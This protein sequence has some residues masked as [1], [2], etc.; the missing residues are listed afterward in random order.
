MKRSRGIY[1]SHMRKPTTAFAEYTSL[2]QRLVVTSTSLLFACSS[3]TSLYQ[4]TQIFRN[5]AECESKH[6][7]FTENECEYA[8]RRANK[9]ALR[10]GP[11]FMSLNN[12]EYEFGYAACYLYRAQLD[13]DTASAEAVAAQTIRD[14]GVIPPN[15]WFMPH[16]SGILLGNMLSPDLN[17]CPSGYYKTLWGCQASTAVYH[18]GGGQGDYKA[19]WYGVNGF[20]YGNSQHR[21]MTI[22]K[23]KFSPKPTVTKTVD[24]RG[25]GYI[26]RR[27]SSSGMSSISGWG[28]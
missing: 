11:K 7:E 28:T 20:F 8:F 26:A 17:S 21:Q 23:A 10:A 22:T 2:A 6:S 25:F 4:K 15:D 9:E 5:V 19:G 18:L 13:H 16:V 3:E 24:R 1:L 27:K 12:C 14:L